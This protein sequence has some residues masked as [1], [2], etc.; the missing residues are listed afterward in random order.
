V[1]AKP[2]LI[3]FL[4]VIAIAVAVS[5]YVSRTVDKAAKSVSAVASPD[6]KYKAVRISLAGGGAAPFCFDTI[7]IFLA[8]YPDSFAESDKTYEVYGA[9]CAAPDKRKDLPKIEWLSNTAVK[10][11]Y[12][13]SA[14]DAKKPRMQTIDASK[15]VHVTF[16]ARE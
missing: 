1:R 10:I 8:V 14:A 13:A 11:T 4:A 15:F 3:G 9:P 12:A 2:F 7:A 5:I 16:V 6:G